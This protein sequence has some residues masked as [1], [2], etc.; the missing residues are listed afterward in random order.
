MLAPTWSPFGAVLYEMAT[1]ALPFRGETS[2]LIF[3]AILDGKPTSAV[4]LNPDLPAELER[5]INKALEKDRDVRHQHASDIKADLKRLRHD[6]ESGQSSVESRGI[7][8]LVAP[9]DVDRRSIVLL[10]ALIAVAAFYLGSGG[11][12]PINSVAVLP[13]ANASA[14]PSMD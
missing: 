8:P 2:G 5:I 1:G 4:R 6:T 13:F 3:K 11:H 7:L 10:I 9:E 14:D 12:A